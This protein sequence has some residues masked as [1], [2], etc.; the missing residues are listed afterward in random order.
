MHLSWD[1]CKKWDTQIIVSV[2]ISEYFL[3]GHNHKDYARWPLVATISPLDKWAS[4]LI[5]AEEC[6]FADMH[7]WYQTHPLLFKISCLCGPFRKIS[8]RITGSTERVTH[9]RQLSFFRIAM[10][11]PE[12]RTACLGWI[13]AKPLPNTWSSMI[14]LHY[15]EHIYIC[16]TIIVKY[17]E[18]WGKEWGDT[19]GV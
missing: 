17:Y 12:V 9:Y 2:S 8:H 18:N 15:V 5:W 6:I 19:R 3:W 16:F 7:S 10:S 4:L 14:L 1:T 11:P 13:C